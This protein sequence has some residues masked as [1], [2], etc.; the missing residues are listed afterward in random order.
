MAKYT[1]WER[2][3]VAKC[4]AAGLSYADYAALAGRLRLP[5]APQSTY[6]MMRTYLKTR[7]PE[8]MGDLPPTSMGK[9]R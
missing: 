2:W 8:E 9:L 7:T 1:K 5:V 4:Y 3:F 6:D